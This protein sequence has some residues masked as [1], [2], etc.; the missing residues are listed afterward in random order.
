MCTSCISVMALKPTQHIVAG[1]TRNLVRR[2]C[3]I[4]NHMRQHLDSNVGKNVHNAGN[5]THISKY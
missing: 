3:V 2:R 4:L 5:M 1:V